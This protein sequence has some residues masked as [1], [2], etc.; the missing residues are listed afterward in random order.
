MSLLAEKNVFK[1]GHNDN[2]LVDTYITNI[3]INKILTILFLK[4]TFFAVILF[5]KYKIVFTSCFI[6]KH[7]EFHNF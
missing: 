6:F 1:S 7:A 4:N 5:P 2:V 3:F